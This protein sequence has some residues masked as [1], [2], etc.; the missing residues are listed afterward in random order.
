MLQNYVR[1]QQFRE[2]E[3][4][5]QRFASFCDISCQLGKIISPL[6]E[7]ASRYLCSRKL[8]ADTSIAFAP[9]IKRNIYRKRFT[10]HLLPLH[11]PFQ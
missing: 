10:Y 7:V 2:L 5:L 3:N 8:G 9:T 6:Q 4:L 11:L 1:N